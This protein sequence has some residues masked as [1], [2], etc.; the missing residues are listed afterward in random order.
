[1]A[2]SVTMVPVSKPVSMASTMQKLQ[3]IDCGVICAKEKQSAKKNN[4]NEVG[5]SDYGRCLGAGVDVVG[6]GVGGGAVRL[7]HNDVRDA[8]VREDERES[9][10]QGGSIL[11]R[12]WWRGL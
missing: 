3:P 7:I 10:P 4:Q 6:L 5:R 9:G 8:M 11:L 1:M 12:Q 2:K